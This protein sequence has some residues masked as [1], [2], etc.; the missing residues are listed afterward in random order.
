MSELSQHRSKISN[1]LILRG[2]TVALVPAV[3]AASYVAGNA[4]FVLTAMAAVLALVSLISGK[5][6]KDKP[7]EAI[8][9]A[10]VLVGQA[11]LM[12]AAFASHPW[13]LDSHMLFFALLAIIATLG[14]IPALLAATG[15]VAVHHLSLGLFLPVLVYPSV[16]IWTNIERTVFHAVIVLIE[17]G[18]LARMIHLQS[19]SDAAKDT[20]QAEQLLAAETAT[21]AQ[22][23]S[24]ADRDEAAN[25]VAIL[26]ARLR[27][28]SEGDFGVQITEPLPPAYESL[29]MDFNASVDAVANLL[30]ENTELSESFSSEA[31]AVAAASNSMARGLEVHA[32][33]VNET[34]EAL[35]ELT[36][37][38]AQT[39]TDVSEVDQTFAAAAEKAGHGSHVVGEA[40]STINSIKSSSDEISKIIQ[41]IEDIAFQTNLLALNAGVEAAR[42]GEHGRGFAV[43][44]S[45]VRALSVRTSDAAREVKGLITK[46]AS[47]VAGGVTSV[48]AAGDVLGEIVE[49]VKRASTLISGLAEQTQSQAEGLDAMATS[50]GTIDNGLQRYAA[51]TEE[52]SATGERLADAASD[53]RHSLSRFVVG[54]APAP[55]PTPEDRAA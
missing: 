27:R 34:A 43:V 2:F 18:V 5:S 9:L 15:A 51:E 1:L 32:G 50:I 33:E 3:A 23:A 7:A 44:A 42:A 49:D 22:A 17:T 30:R 39:A 6:A 28:M 8:L 52:L 19:R 29:R 45:E 12:T 31:S 35:R 37:T 16:D 41:V 11:M 54:S 10:L 21:A 4:I 36:G 24:Q 38:V 55:A 25:A 46:S 13:Q 20:A 53:L 47:L 14:S 40:V 48:G 26:G